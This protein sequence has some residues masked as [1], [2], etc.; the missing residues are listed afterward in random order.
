MYLDSADN[1]NDYMIL[2]KIFSFECF[3]ICPGIILSYK[4]SIRQ[5]SIFRR[6]LVSNS[7]HN[8]VNIG[9]VVFRVGCRPVRIFSWRRDTGSSPCTT[10]TGS[11]SLSRYCWQTHKEQVIRL[12]IG[13]C[14]WIGSQLYY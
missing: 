1:I 6:N 8:V 2:C 14:C 5:N 7:Q 4:R 11:R 10:T 3:V 12:F 9:S 13:Y